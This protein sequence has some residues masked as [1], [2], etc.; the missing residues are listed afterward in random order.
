MKI[1]YITNGLTSGGSERVLS[2]L[3]NKMSARG[4]DVDIISVMTTDVFYDLNPSV[5]LLF[6]G[7][8][9]KSEL[10]IKKLLW[11]RKYIVN[12]RPDVVIAFLQ[13]VYCFTILSLLCTGV[14]VI[15]SERNDPKSYGV[16]LP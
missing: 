10:L 1:S 3:A 5:K 8:E 13:R 15:S 16:V 6:M 14:P 7:K 2:L 4:H 12:E 11:L 9:A